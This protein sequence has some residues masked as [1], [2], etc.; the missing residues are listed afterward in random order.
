MM[1]RTGRI[2]EGRAVEDAI[3][4]MAMTLATASVRRACRPVRNEPGKGRV[5]WMGGGKG[6]GRQRRKG[7]GRETVKGKVLL[8]KPQQEMIS[9]MPLLC[10]CKKKMY[11][12]DS[13][14]EG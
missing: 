7:R 2:L 6:R 8:N 13:N 3:M 5:Q 11:E 12:A 9:R 10:S 1:T 4:V 14:M